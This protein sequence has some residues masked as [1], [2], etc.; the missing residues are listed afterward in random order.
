MPELRFWHFKAQQQN[1]DIYCL[2]L[3]LLEVFLSYFLHPD[4]FTVIYSWQHHSE[5]READKK[6]LLGN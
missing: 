1:T 2:F 4:L 5:H 3:C 6:S